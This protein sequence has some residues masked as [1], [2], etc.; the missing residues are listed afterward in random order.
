MVDRVHLREPAP[1]GR[2]LVV[3]LALFAEMI[4]SK[5]WTPATLKEVGGTEGI[6]VTFLEE[7]FTATTASLTART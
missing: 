1:L 2:R 5:A 7:T 6:G 4:K 3:R